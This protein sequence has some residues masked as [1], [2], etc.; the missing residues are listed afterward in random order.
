M[1]DE[2][3][4][5]LTEAMSI[6]FWLGHSTC[7]KCKTGRRVNAINFSTSESFFILWKWSLKQNWWLKFESRWTDYDNILDLID[8]DKLADSVYEFLKVRK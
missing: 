4:K 5:F 1:N 7:D 6:C 3:D 8:P 2:R